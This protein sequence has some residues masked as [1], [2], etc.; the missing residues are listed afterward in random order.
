[1]SQW[2]IKRTM[3]AEIDLMKPPTPRFGDPKKFRKCF[4]VI[5]KM[6]KNCVGQDNVDAV[7]RQIQQLGATS[8][9]PQNVIR[10][11][12]SFEQPINGSRIDLGMLLYQLGAEDSIKVRMVVWIPRS[13][14]AISEDRGRALTCQEQN[15][16]EINTWSNFQDCLVAQ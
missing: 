6:L 9:T 16:S 13:E 12:M 3:I 10:V 1:M 11:A 15:R 2:P 5:L 14:K 4:R 7:I 8:D